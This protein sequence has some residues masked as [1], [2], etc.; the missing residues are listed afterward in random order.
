MDLQPVP[1]KDTGCARALGMIEAGQPASAHWT[2]LCFGVGAGAI[3][4]VIVEVGTLSHPPE[5]D[6][7]SCGVAEPKQYRRRVRDHVREGRCLCGRACSAEVE[8]AVRSVGG[9]RTAA[10]PR[11]ILSP[12][13]ELPD[14]HF[15]SVV[16]ATIAWPRPPRQ[17]QKN[18]PRSRPQMTVRGCD[19]LP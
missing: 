5:R 12:D 6:S 14:M 1:F 10:A 11:T 15:E 19:G 9:Q 18:P 7:R 4:Q 8:A 17:L 3:A 13:I 2:A 16:V